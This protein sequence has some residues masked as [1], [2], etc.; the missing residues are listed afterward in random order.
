MILEPNT[1]GLPPVPAS[2]LE[3]AMP[4]VIKALKSDGSFT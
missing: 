2:V 3:A 4:T 1:V